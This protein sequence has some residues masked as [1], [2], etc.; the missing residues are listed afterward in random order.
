MAKLTLELGGKYTA[1]QV[2]S[3]AQQDIK[4][5]GQET[6]DIG[7][8][9]SASLDAITGKINGPL[10]DSM[11]AASGMIKGLASGGLWG[12]VSA[13]A[14]AA[15]GYIVTK[16]NEAKESAKKFSEYMSTQM[17]ESI[18]GIN[19]EFEGTRGAI[20]DAQKAAEDALG[21]LNGKSAAELSNKVY[22][23][24]TKALQQVT[25][26]MTEKGKAVIAAQEKLDVALLKQSEMS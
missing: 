13:A 26:G 18:K 14:G 15:I 24:H 4:K 16:W 9:G 2:F 3:K 17:V 10:K 21:V 6:K 25:D 5:F 8:I 23:I 7:R 11:N 12:V 20:K 1:G 22:E 19:K